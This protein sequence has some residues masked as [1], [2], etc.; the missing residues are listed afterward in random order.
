MLEDK[1]AP[2]LITLTPWVN[3]QHHPSQMRLEKVKLKNFRKAKDVTFDLSR[4][5]V[6]IGPN[7]SGKSTVLDS[8]RFLATAAATGSFAEA[9]HDRGGFLNL[10]WKGDQASVV[11]I[12]TTFAED[13]DAAGSARRYVWSVRLQRLGQSARDVA[14]HETLEFVQ[15]NAPP[16]QYLKNAPDEKWWWSVREDGVQDKMTL[17][18]DALECALF[19]AGRQI[20]FPGRRVFQHL[21]CWS[22]SDPNPGALKLPS[23][24]SRPQA[25]D[26]YGRNLASR[27]QVV[28]ETEPERY[29]DVVAAVRAITGLPITNIEVRE[30]E[31]DRVG[32]TISEAGLKYP[33]NQPSVS[34]G[35]LRVLAIALAIMGAD[36]A[37]L[38]G[39]EEPENY[40]H[41]EALQGLAQLLAQA[42]DS[43]QVVVT[44]HSPLL[45]NYLGPDAASIFVVDSGD[46]RGTTVRRAATAT[47]LVEALEKAEFGWGDY[48]LTK[49]FGGAE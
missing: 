41:P 26:I 34:S 30:L 2:D 22:F 11:E 42:S 7:A 48:L 27:L 44:T 45:L 35:T 17:D 4:F 32:F 3:A 25:L 6:L 36:S 13:E 1:P 37:Q 12:T 49:G 20:A 21:S 28:Q 9:I 43:T 40:L 15:S 24:A 29:A 19:L 31:N 18:L 38:L 16:V 8:L 23:D 5:S 39:L 46:N 14:V 33:V 10:A 47:S